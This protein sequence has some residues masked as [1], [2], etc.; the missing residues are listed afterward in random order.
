M[1]NMLNQPP[2]WYRDP[3]QPNRHRYWSGRGW[4]GPVGENLQVWSQVL[5]EPRPPTPDS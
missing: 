5:C 1:K 2:G 4:I 3:V